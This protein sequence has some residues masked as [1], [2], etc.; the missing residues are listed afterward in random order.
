MMASYRVH[1][2]IGHAHDEGELP[3]GREW[4]VVTDSD[5]V[6]AGLEADLDVVTARQVAATPVLTVATVDSVARAMQLMTEHEVAHAIVVERHSG[7]P[8]G[9][10][11]TLDVA[12]SLSGAA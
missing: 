1:A 7:R 8:V 2:I 6:C 4:G 3:G 11:S 9:V 12:R 10:L 5:L